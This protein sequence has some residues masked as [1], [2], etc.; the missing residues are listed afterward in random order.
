MH[1][2]AFTGG[3]QTIFVHASLLVV[4]ILAFGWEVSGDARNN[5]AIFRASLPGWLGAGRRVQKIIQRKILR[6]V[7]DDYNRSSLQP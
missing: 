2:R 5:A 7:I 3:I 6:T 4:A 1:H